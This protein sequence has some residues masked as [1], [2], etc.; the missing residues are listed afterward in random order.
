V[1]NIGV[2]E[3]LKFLEIENKILAVNKQGKNHMI[4]F[5]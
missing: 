3:F 5:K 2:N 1:I 4:D